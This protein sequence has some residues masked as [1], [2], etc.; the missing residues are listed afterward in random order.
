MQ[1]HADR[2]DKRSA[3]LL[4]RAAH[5]DP[6]GWPKPTSL[7]GQEGTHELQPHHHQQPNDHQQQQ[8]HCVIPNNDVARYSRQDMDRHVGPQA[9]NNG[10]SSE[11]MLYNVEQKQ[12]TSASAFTPIQSS[13]LSSATARNAVAAAYFPYESFGFGIG[14]GGGVDMKA[15]EGKQTSHGHSSFPNQLIALH[16][17][18]NYASMPSGTGSSSLTEHPIS[19]I[20]DKPQ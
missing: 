8:Q 20:K 1:K 6:Y 11:D 2:M 16:Q 5:T 13:M 17:I 15:M 4:G 3:A 10:R 9:L 19:G 14:T 7:V 12:A 18:R